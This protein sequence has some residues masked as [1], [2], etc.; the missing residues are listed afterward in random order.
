M[1]LLFPFPWL[2]FKHPVFY[3]STN[4]GFVGGIMFLGFT[5]VNACIWACV[6]PAHNLIKKWTDFHQT[7]VDDVFEVTDELIR[8]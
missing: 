3:A 2:L 1:T 5:S 4:D 8:F 7:L 6:L